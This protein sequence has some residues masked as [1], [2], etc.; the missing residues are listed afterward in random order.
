MNSIKKSAGNCEHN[1]ATLL[2]I[3]FIAD[4]TGLRP[5]HEAGAIPPH[6]QAA[7]TAL[8]D[9]IC[10]LA[11]ERVEKTEADFAALLMA[12]NERA[13]KAEAENK[14]IVKFVRRA[15][16]GLESDA[17]ITE[18]MNDLRAALDHKEPST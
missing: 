14:R 16:N 4:A 17:S 12:R 15:L 10:K 8:C 13:E 18:V 11:R 9:G 2:G 3:E 5:P 1:R 6:M 7:F